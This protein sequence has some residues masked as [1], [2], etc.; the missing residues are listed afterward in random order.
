MHVFHSLPSSFVMSVV[1]AYDCWCH[2]IMQD[3]KLKDIDVDIDD[4]KSKE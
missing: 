2:F 3:L 1:K 4:I